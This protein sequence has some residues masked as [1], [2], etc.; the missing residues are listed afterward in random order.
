MYLQIT[1]A[2]VPEAQQTK[3]STSVRIVEE[4]VVP[5]SETTVGSARSMAKSE[6][7]Q[8]VL[9]PA[10]EEPKLTGKFY[11]RKKP[12]MDA[13]VRHESFSTV[14]WYVFFKTKHPEFKALLKSLWTTSLIVVNFQR[15][16]QK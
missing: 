5:H 11:L 13:P 1:A 2:I 10:L 8:T 12:I 6:I 16:L 15:L 3:H 9:A 4:D 7:L 14:S